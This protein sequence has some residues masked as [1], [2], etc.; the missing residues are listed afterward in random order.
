LLP[1]LVS[2]R[3]W[4]PMRTTSALPDSLSTR[5]GRARARKM[6]LSIASAGSSSA[7]RSASI[8]AKR[9]TESSSGS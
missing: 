1:V 3:S 6:S 8:A 9:L 7:A 5:K 2:V 4:S